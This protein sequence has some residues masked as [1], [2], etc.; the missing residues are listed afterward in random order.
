MKVFRFCFWI[1]YFKDH[2]RTIQIFGKK[3][4]FYHFWWLAP[5]NSKKLLSCQ[6]IGENQNLEGYNEIE[7]RER[8]WFVIFH[9]NYRTKIIKEYQE[10]CLS[11]KPYCSDIIKCWNHQK[12]QWYVTYLLFF[13]N[14]SEIFCFSIFSSLNHLQYL[15][16]PQVLSNKRWDTPERPILGVI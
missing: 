15:A 10:A 7:S 5:G 3:T 11:N 12:K 9:V 16:C 2:I 8:Y 13:K 1:F 6:H 4:N 14:F